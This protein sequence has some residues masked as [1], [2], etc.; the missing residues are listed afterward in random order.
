MA[1]KNTSRRK[2]SKKKNK[3]S[4]WK[5]SARIL[6]AV[7]TTIVCIFILAF[8]YDYFTSEKKDSSKAKVEKKEIVS[9]E[10]TKPAP[11][12]QE[13][14]RTTTKKAEPV[15]KLSVNG[16]I[17]ILK[18]N[19]NEQIIK[20]TGYTV[21]YNSD[22]KIANWVAYELTKKEVTDANEKRTNKFVYDP[23][24]KGASASRE[25]YAKSGY[26]KGHMAPAGDM[27]WSA[28]AMQE[29]FYLS[30]ICPQKPALNRGIWQ[31]LEETI[32]VW[33]KEYGELYVVCGPVIEDNLKRLGKNR[34]GIPN[35]FYK[36]VCD[37]K[38]GRAI[39][40]IFENR[41]YKDTDL[42]NYVITVDSVEKVTGIDFF[43]NFPDDIERKME[44]QVDF[45][46]SFF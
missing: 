42:R 14:S 2:I 35:K 41:G 16:E 37:P 45:K 22:Y 21:S 31:S 27:K 36:V 20:H 30:N 46:W 15:S 24:V 9:P 32:R 5:A 17:P 11:A 7:C 12:K 1:K 26:D 8:L 25:D 13:P 33:A 3:S 23:K 38:G 29:S 43:P 19:R 28:R 6:S 39:G 10:T 4:I 44:S 40:F 34:V 18:T